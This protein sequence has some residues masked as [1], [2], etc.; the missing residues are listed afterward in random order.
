MLLDIGL[1]GMSG[2]DV[3]RELR[4]H[5]EYKDLILAAM[6]GYGQADDRRRSKEA[7]FDQH[8][9]KPIDPAL[10]EAFLAAPRSFAMA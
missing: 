1:P 9:T 2:Y 6:T 8:L 7:G 3:A 10:L 5:L 4:Q